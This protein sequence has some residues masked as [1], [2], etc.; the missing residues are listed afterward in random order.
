MIVCVHALAQVHPA[1][2][3][4]KAVRAIPL[5]LNV[6]TQTTTQSQAKHESLKTMSR[7]YM[8]QEIYRKTPTLLALGSI[9]NRIPILSLTSRP[10]PR[11]IAQDKSNG[12]HRPTFVSGQAIIELWRHLPQ[13]GQPSPGYGGEIMMFVMISDIVRQDV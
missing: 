5:I 7:L 10:Q 6:S 4:P 8:E 13:L 11:I 3:T 12:H 9:P 2:S 1:L